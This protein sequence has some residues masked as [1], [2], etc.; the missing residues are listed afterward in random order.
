M[1]AIVISSGH[2][3]KV[4]GASGFCDEVNEAR[5][6]VD[7]V[8]QRLHEAGAACKKY[9]DD[10]S[11]TQNENLRR[12]TD[13]HNSQQ[14]DLD[15]SVHFNAY[16]AT[17]KPMGVEV[18]YVS[19]QALAAD[20]SRKLAAT[21]GLPDR[22]GKK[23]TDLY[24]LNNTSKPAI[25]IEV[26]FCDSSA[27]TE[28]YGRMLD[29][30]CRV[31]A[32]VTAD[33]Q[34]TPEPPLE[35]DAPPP[36][37]LPET[38]RIDMTIVS[39][40]PVTVTINGQDF[41][42]PPPPDPEAPVGLVWHTSIETTR[43]G[44]AADPNTSAYPPYAFIDDKVLGCALPY[45]FPGARDLVIIRNL[46]NGKQQICEIVDLGPWMIDDWAYVLDGDRPLAELCYNSGA[47]LPSGPNAGKVPTNAAGLDV[48]P[49]ADKALGLDGKGKCDWAFY[50][51]PPPEAV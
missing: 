51:P 31:I 40:G 48:T 25:L 30:V 8:D 28:A 39:T 13:Y 4:R 44:G 21:M 5:R 41:Q 38:A 43:F 7:A 16:S 23:R 18:L 12:I 22:G 50:K 2:G 10:V 49:A 17:A 46:A 19:Q 14:R 33:L 3:L 6:V 9:H 47:A 15:V 32:E 34:V 27:D 29:D 26:C 24:F 35:P 1:R 42:V 11:T 45:K 20:L 37:P 36:E